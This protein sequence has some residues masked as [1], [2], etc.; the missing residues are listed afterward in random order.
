MWKLYCHSSHLDRVDKTDLKN[1]CKSSHIGQTVKRTG[2]HVTLIMLKK[3]NCI[4][5]DITIINF[6]ILEW[7]SITKSTTNAKDSEVIK[8]VRGV[9][10]NQLKN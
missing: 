3:L 4:Q 6:L 10:V 5:Y 9:W 2:C 1:R 7:I 8:K